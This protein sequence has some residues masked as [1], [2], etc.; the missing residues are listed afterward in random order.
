[1]LCQ[2]MFA[3]RDLIQQPKKTSTAK[4][5]I[6]SMF[7]RTVPQESIKQLNH[8]V[9]VGL[10]KGLEPLR[11]VKSKGFLYIAQT[12]IDF[13]AKYGSQRAEDVINHQ[14]TLKRTHSPQIRKS[15]EENIKK[16]LQEAPSYPTFSFTSDL[17]TEK[18]QCTTF[19][20]L[21]AHYIDSDWKV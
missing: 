14:T 20:A 12:L 6:T 18:H 17:W 13:G 11:R 5:T 16:S 7:S 1:M 15:Q 19:L 2:G 8:D 10:A 4:G 3:N 21:S 9:T